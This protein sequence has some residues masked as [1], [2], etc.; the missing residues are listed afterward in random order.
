[1]DDVSFLIGC[2]FSELDFSVSGL[3][4]FFL[5]LQPLVCNWKGSVLSLLRGVRVDDNEGIQL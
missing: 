5:F 2:L 3:F 1:M 4:S